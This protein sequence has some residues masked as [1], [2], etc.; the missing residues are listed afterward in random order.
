MS[1]EDNRPNLCLLTESIIKFPETRFS[2]NEPLSEDEVSTV[3]IPVIRMG[4]LTQTSVVRVFTKDGSAKS[5]MDYNPL[6]QRK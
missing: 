2:V 5:G 6:S 3:R 1:S 4:D